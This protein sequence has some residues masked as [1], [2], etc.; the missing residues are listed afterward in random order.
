MYVYRVA[1]HADID[2]MQVVR[3]AVKENAL[4]HP[5]RIS[6][7]DYLPYLQEQGSGWV[8]L[9]NN[10]VVGFAIADRIEGSIWA[11]FVLP[12]YE[13]NG[14]GKELHRMMMNGYFAHSDKTVWL[15]TAFDTRAE[16]FYRRQ[17]WRDAGM[18]NAIER[19]FE[20]SKQEWK[21]KQPAACT[22]R[23]ATIQDAE[24]IADLSRKTF[25]D[26]FAPDNTVEDMDIFLSQQFTRGKLMLEVGRPELHF[27][28]AYV[29]DVVAGYVK[30]REGKLPQQAVS[31]TALEIARLYAEQ[32]F[33][34]KGVG[35]ALMAE[36][37][38]IARERNK[39]WV[40]LGVWE[41]NAR[42]IAFYQRWGF[43]KFGEC[44][45]HLGRDIQRDWLMRKDVSRES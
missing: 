38:R 18:H 32:A 10:R 20:L 3:R 40:W 39:Q 22:L 45:F 8:A 23:T 16:E 41:H 7:E 4:S 9:H 17:G 35:A 29:D 43:E 42:A 34:G 1:T 13:G 25:Y 44:D 21:A 30:L 6:N 14:I 24:L 26:S 28:L 37:I 2:A 15:T 31:G 19:K 5:D 11:L 33:V 27:I 36:S 12:E